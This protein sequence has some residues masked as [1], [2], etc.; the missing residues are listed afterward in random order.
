MTTF[1]YRT[2]YLH[3]I[4]HAL[5]QTRFYPVSYHIHRKAAYEA[6]AQ[7]EED[8]QADFQEDLQ[9]SRFNPTWIVQRCPLGSNEWEQDSQ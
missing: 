5:R 4:G 6:L 8:F 2:G 3:P 7:H 1:I 9:Q